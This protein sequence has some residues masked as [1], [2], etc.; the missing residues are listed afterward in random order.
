M[1]I[2][3]PIDGSSYS[4]NSLEF[5]A[6]RATLLGKNPEIELLVVLAPLPTRAARL[7]SK[8][9]SSAIP[10]KRSPKKQPNSPPTSSSWGAAAARP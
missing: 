1:K 10:R 5:V 4:D 7:V 2:L 3:V 8:D 9:S 6:S